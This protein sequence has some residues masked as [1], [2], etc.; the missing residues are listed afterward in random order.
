MPITLSG[1][2]NVKPKR[3]KQ[4]L[5]VLL[6]ERAK[7]SGV[8]TD[9]GDVIVYGPVLR[10]HNVNW[11]FGVSSNRPPNTIGD[12]CRTEINKIAGELQAKFDLGKD[13]KT[14]RELEIMI[15]ERVGCSPLQ[16]VVMNTNSQGW[17][18]KAMTNDKQAG[19]LQPNVDIAVAELRQQYD[20]AE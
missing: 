20:L 10:P 13:E 17:F 4:Q 14:A 15:A 5:Q 11:D 2:S 18:A 12:N 9:L 3:T 16:V 1:K 8:C 19:A 7:A 6:A